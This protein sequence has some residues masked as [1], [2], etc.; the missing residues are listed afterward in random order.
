MVC[1]VVGYCLRIFENRNMPILF[2]GMVVYVSLD[3][4]TGMYGTYIRVYY[5]PHR[6]RATKA[7][8]C[9]EFDFNE[10]VLL[11]MPHLFYEKC[12]CINVYLYCSWFS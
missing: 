12:I 6:M 7:D 9:F 4:N 10:D 2:E 5:Q 3:R 11:T 1:S 8:D